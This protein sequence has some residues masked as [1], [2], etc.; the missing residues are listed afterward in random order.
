MTDSGKVLMVDNNSTSVQS[1]TQSVKKYQQLR[2]SNSAKDKNINPDIFDGMVARSEIM[3]EIM[4]KVLK[5][6]N[7][8]ANVLIYGDS[9]TGKELLARSIHNRSRLSSEAFIP[10]DCVALP[11]NLLGKR[12]VATRKVRSPGL[13]PCE[14]DCWSMQMEEPFF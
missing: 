13:N 10:I 8:K 5:I 12:V 11:D 1:L 4:G 6:S 7:S 2:K 14:G 9:G 3:Q